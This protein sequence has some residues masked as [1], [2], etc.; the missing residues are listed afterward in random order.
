LDRPLL[1]F[2]GH[3]GFCRIWIEYFRKRAGGHLDF[4]PSQ[5]AGHRYPQIPRE[6]FAKSVQLVRADGSVASGARAV[7]EALRW[8]RAY[9]SVPALAP[10]SE[11][12]Y[13]TIAAHRDVFYWVT[14]L[15]VGTRIEPASFA[16]TQWLFLRALAAIY[17]IAFASLAVQVRGLMGERGIVP[18]GEFLG[19]VKRALGAA[20]Y[21]DVP[22]VF[23]LAS[24]DAVLQGAAWVG[25]ALAALVFVGRFERAGLALLWVLYLSFSTAGQVFLAYQWDALLL[26]AGFLAIF[27]GR[28]AAQRKTI[29]WL[30]RLLAFRL[31]F[32]S[33]W[34][35]IASGDPN[36]PA[37]R[38][39][40]F[41][42]RTQPLPNILAWYADKLPRWFQTTSTFGVLAIELAAPFLIFGPRRWRLAGA[43]AMLGLQAL[44]FATGNYTFFNLLAVALLLFVFD[45]RALKAGPPLGPARARFV[46]ARWALASFLGVAGLLR[47]AE[48]MNGVLPRPLALIAHTGPPLMIVNPYGLFAVMTTTRPEIVIQGSNDGEYWLDYEFHYKP[49]DVNRAPLQVAPHQPRLDWQMW[50]AAL[51]DV[52]SSPWFLSFAEKLLD[53]SP[54]VARL[55]ARNPFPDRPPRY[56]RALLYEYSFA[57]RATHAATGAW[58]RREPRGTFLPA[59]ALRNFQ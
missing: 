12:A 25:V 49:G 54:E 4:A 15:T 30:Y 17:A 22:G 26:E 57:D 31:Y 50:F 45:D 58:W 1:I 51:D 53:G 42:Y 47:I 37:L 35:K 56:I 10:L 55:L 23:W 20:G 52:R 29:A 9:E 27:F 24:S 19:Q 11:W 28:S 2:D 40:D 41:H 5:E 32:L 7:F 13:R 59:I 34:V 6:D 43:W 3:C 16:K 48:S 21:Y 18:V 8:E 33:G 38:A 46:A 44:I 39:L 14:R 36:W